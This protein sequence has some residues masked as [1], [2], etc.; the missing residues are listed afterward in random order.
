VG[1]RFV[2][3]LSASHEMEMGAA[4]ADARL[5]RPERF[6]HKPLGL[7]VECLERKHGGPRCR[8][9]NGNWHNLTCHKRKL[10]GDDVRDAENRLL[11]RKAFL[12]R[13]FQPK[14]SR[15]YGQIAMVARR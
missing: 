13:F 4:D 10:K 5:R 11:H 9:Q 1:V 6:A 14:N 8:A 7:Y 2:R 15:R 12:S 3:A